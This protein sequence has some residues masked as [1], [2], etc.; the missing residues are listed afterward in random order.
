MV[1]EK[2]KLGRV[3]ETPRGTGDSHGKQM[4]HDKQDAMRGEV[5]GMPNGTS[6]RQSPEE[7]SL[8]LRR[9]A[10]EGRAITGF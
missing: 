2:T 3:K 5:H 4:E 8:P 6:L 1:H 7:R 9:S 10:A